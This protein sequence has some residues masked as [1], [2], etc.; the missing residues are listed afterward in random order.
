MTDHAEL[1]QPTAYQ[2]MFTA[3]GVVG[4]AAPDEK[5]ES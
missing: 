1:E 2:L 3:S 4:T 5:D